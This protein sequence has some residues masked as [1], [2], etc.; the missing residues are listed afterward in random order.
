MKRIYKLVTH[1]NIKRYL[2]NIGCLLV[3]ASVSGCDDFLDK[4][5][6]DKLV[7]DSYW[8]DEVS[9]RAYSQD[10]YSSYFVGY[11]Q[12]YRAFGGYFSGDSYNDDFLLTSDNVSDT[13]QRLFFPT[14]NTNGINSVTTPWTDQY[15][16]VR[17]ANVMLEKIPEMNISDEA[18]KHW[19]G[20]AYFFRATAYSALVKT[21]GDVPYIDVAVADAKDYEILYKD[22]DPQVTVVNKILEDYS[23]AL[24]NVR[25]NDGVRQV[26]KSVVGAFMSRN[27]LYHATWLKYHGTTIGTSSKQ[28]GNEEL[29]KFFKGAIDGAES[30][31]GSG[32]YSIGDTYNALFTSESLANNPEII[33]YREYTTGV[34]ANALMAYNAKEDQRL[35]GVTIDAI[36]SYPCLDGL[37]IGQ[38]SLYGGSTDPS[39]KNSFKDRDPRIYDTFVDTL[40]ILNSGLFSAASPTGFASKK[41]LNEEWLL[42]DSPYVT[43]LLS[44]ADAPVIR[45]AEVLLNYVE[46]RYE[47]SKIGGV[48]F[49]Q[50][51]L[52]K[53]INEIR[54]RSLTKWGETPAVN[55]KLPTVT[56]SG[57]SI[58]VNNTIIDDPDRDPSVDPILWE[59]RRERRVELMME[60]RRSDDL[61]RWAKFEYLNT[62]VANNPNRKV[63]GAWINKADYPGISTAVKLFNP[64]DPGEAPT[65]GYISYF[66]YS[67]PLRSFVKGD[68][69]SER[70]YLRSIPAAQITIYKDQGYT[71]TQN[72]G[73]E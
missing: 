11:A 62:G 44:P 54:R 63:L 3:L 9:L 72:P 32:K 6:L 47:I 23:C 43:G 13:N 18:K 38:S 36:N 66:S 67:S 27:M 1:I 29:S 19:M 21:Y 7:N 17:K 14:A 50:T 24:Q 69:N 26:N 61:N 37:P 49:S 5:P 15:K 20:I 71:L 42:K 45:Y 31:M 34:A 53:S 58:A 60:G 10:F 48:A 22:R 8:V 33:F 70:N 65:E 52:D 56:L 30:V 28:V 57:S 35:G 68:I 39:I 2:L 64:G 25:E 40:R 51:D 59:I 16:I 41:F 4:P 12:D 55:R 73:W 46:A